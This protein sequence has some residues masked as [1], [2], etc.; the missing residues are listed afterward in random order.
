MHMYIH[1]YIYFYIM[2]YAYIYIHIH[3]NLIY[4]KMH[5]VYITSVE[6]L[7]CLVILG[8]FPYKTTIKGTRK[9]NSGNKITDR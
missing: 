7:Y 5:N 9:S 4:I 2:T 3:T 6:L 8:Q 1:I